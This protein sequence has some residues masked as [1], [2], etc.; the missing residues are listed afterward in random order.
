M[1]LKHKKKH[2]I[3]RNLTV[4]IVSQIHTIDITSKN[5]IKSI[6]LVIWFHTLITLMNENRSR[7]ASVVGLVSF[8]IMTVYG[9]SAGKKF[10]DLA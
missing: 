7:P 3:K 9:L 4:Q 10:D 5:D 1:T 6:V 2:R 8:A